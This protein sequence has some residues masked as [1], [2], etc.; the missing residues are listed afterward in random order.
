MAKRALIGTLTFCVFF[1]VAGAANARD[2]SDCERNGS[3]ARLAASAT[4]TEQQPVAKTPARDCPDL[5]ADAGAGTSARSATATAVPMPQAPASSALPAEVGA[6]SVIHAKDFTVLVKRPENATGET[7]VLLHGSGGD[8]TTLMSLASRIAP[9]AVLMGIRGRVV[10][11]G[12]K[13]W[14][15]R[16]TPTR[17]DQND[18]RG[19]ANAFASFLHGMVKRRMLDLDHTTFLGYSNG[20]NLLA[21]LSVL[22]PGL[23]ERA[24]LLRPMSVLDK[25]PDVSLSGTR[26]LIVAGDTDQ[27]YAPLAPALEAM[28]R[29]HGARLDIRS[30]KANHGLGDE[31]AKIAGEWLARSTAVSLN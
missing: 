10:Q 3:Q 23:I 8:E 28:L 4:K 1:G 16:I 24:I 20:A 6:S 7:L 12:K 30:I 21:A 5:S 14:Y 31:D 29:D 22:H 11:D 9:R 2:L 25:V 13:R 26:F 19:E 27:T 17:F 18:I 15:K